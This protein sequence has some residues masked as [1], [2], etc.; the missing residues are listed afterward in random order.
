MTFREERYQQQASTSEAVMEKRKLR[1]KMAEG[2]NVAFESQ[3]IDEEPKVICVDDDDMSG[4]NKPSRTTDGDEKE[5]AHASPVE[6]SSDGVSEEPQ[7]SHKVR[8]IN[9]KQLRL[10]NKVLVLRLMKEKLFFR[11]DERKTKDAA[12]TQPLEQSSS[13][14][15]ASR[16]RH[17]A[18]K[19]GDKS[20]TVKRKRKSVYQSSEDEAPQTKHA[21]QVSSIDSDHPPSRKPPKHHKKKAACVVP[22]A[23]KSKQSGAVIKSRSKSSS[24]SDTDS[25]QAVD[26]DPKGHVKSTRSHLV[27][28]AE[29]I[30]MNYRPKNKIN[31]DPLAEL[32]FRDRLSPEI[33]LQ[34]SNSSQEEDAIDEIDVVNTLPQPQHISAESSDE[35]VCI[36]KVKHIWRKNNKPKG[37]ER[38]KMDA[39]DEQVFVITQKNVLPS[40]KAVNQVEKKVRNGKRSRILLISDSFFDAPRAELESSDS[41]LSADGLPRQLSA[42]GAEGDIEEE[43]EQPASSVAQMVH[44]KSD[45][46]HRDEDCS[47]LLEKRAK[48]GNGGGDKGVGTKRKRIDEPH[49]AEGRKK[50]LPHPMLGLP[51]VVLSLKQIDA[52]RKSD[53]YR[54]KSKK[55]KNNRKLRTEQPTGKA[56]DLGRDHELLVTDVLRTA[57]SGDGAELKKTAKDRTKKVKKNS[58]SKTWPTE[59]EK[60]QSTTKPLSSPL[61]VATSR[62]KIKNRKKTKVDGKVIS[63]DSQDSQTS[64]EEIVTSKN[65]PSSPNHN[66]TTQPLNK[67]I[68]VYNGLER[69][70]CVL[71]GDALVLQPLPTVRDHA[72]S[73]EEGMRIDSQ[74]AVQQ[75]LKALS[76]TTMASEGSSNKKKKSSQTKQNPQA[77]ASKKRPPLDRLD[78]NG[79]GRSGVHG[80]SSY[81][82]RSLPDLIPVKASEVKRE[83]L[84]NEGSPSSD[85][86]SELLMM[87]NS[88]VESKDDQTDKLGRGVNA[89]ESSGEKES[90]V[91]EETA[92]KDPKLQSG[93]VVA[94]HVATSSGSSDCESESVQEKNRKS[95]KPPKPISKANTSKANKPSKE[96]ERKKKER[97]KEDLRVLATLLPSYSPIALKDLGGGGAAMIN[98]DDDSSTRTKEKPSVQVASEKATT[99]VA[100]PSTRQQSLNRL[101]QNT[102][103]TNRE[104]VLSNRT[105][106]TS[107]VTLT[108]TT[109]RS[110]C[111]SSLFDEGDSDM[112]YRKKRKTLLNKKDIS[113][114]FQLSVVKDQVYIA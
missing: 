66:V 58:K 54:D 16:V 18:G 36:K 19:D 109:K 112:S 22:R 21:R 1:K 93:H 35:E 65:K 105:L 98:R 74:H 43:R 30:T 76:A 68:E 15:L 60:T 67:L 7:L 44:K 33:P 104:S 103:R 51:P 94:H 101:Q 10:N 63:L 107:N 85:Q 9:T 29:S 61:S 62:E 52:G 106:G 8:R 102:A 11:K 23:L 84:S 100:F 75:Q 92:R 95:T 50:R 5:S 14:R 53:L 83:S 69:S 80:E 32:R 26:R 47:T 34:N 70:L 99:S 86:P 46:T 40:K 4:H 59:E 48:I 96:N 24:E 6:H 82:P 57:I 56:A 91:V 89:K 79:G 39:A 113:S 77:K 114:A 90:K 97:E 2:I 25:R 71:E 41:K 111:S 110:A 73:R 31:T 37:N 45:A 78:E 3:K 27:N 88:I 81:D 55:K 38:G 17:T 87:V 72:T 12:T 20:K 64:A 28:I 13:V 49:D 42:S 108:G